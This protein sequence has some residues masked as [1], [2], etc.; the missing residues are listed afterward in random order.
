MEQ[1][2]TNDFLLQ[3]DLAKTLYHNFAKDMPIIDYHCHIDPREIAEDINF[4][5]ITEMWLKHDHYKWRLM[6][7]NGIDECL[8]T[9]DAS[10]YDKFIAFVKTLEASFGNP[11]YHWS[12][13]ELKNYFD[14]DYELNSETADM[15]WNICNEKIN[16]G[17]LSA[18]KIIK[19]SNVKCI[20]TTDDP[21]DDLKWHKMIKED[22]TFS[23]NV[24]PTF[25]PDMLL[26]ITNEGFCEYIS[27]LSDS[28]SFSINSFEELKKA[29]ICRMDYF[30]KLGAKSSDHSFDI[31]PFSIASDTEINEIFLEAITNHKINSEMKEKFDTAIMLFLAKEY[32]KRNWVMQLHFG[33]TRNTNKKMFDRVG[34]DAGFD[35]ILSQVSIENLAKLLDSLDKDDNLPKTVLYSLNPNDNAAIDTLCGC[36]N[37][38]SVK[39][40]VQHGAAWWFNDHITGM[41]NHLESLGNYGLM[42]SFVGMLTDSRSFLSYTRHEYF[43]RILCQFIS[44]KV[45]KGEF[46]KDINRLGKIVKDISYDNTYKYFF[47]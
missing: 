17:K 11:I 30:N 19:M 24:I 1:L 31:I 27:K 42:T 43:R 15:V 33:V 35:R 28:V 6:R 13:L 21:I 4:E 45:N 14:I 34:K 12:H 39:G 7:Q 2:I 26:N 9:G 25:R 5:N 16:S 46:V 44:E 8:I 32:A 38:A 40:K 47:G 3:N 23:C 20:G 22:E 10:D 29:L 36:F 37:E 18:K 41:R